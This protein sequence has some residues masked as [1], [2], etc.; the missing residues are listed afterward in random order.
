M[1]QCGKIW[2]WTGHR[3]QYDKCFACCMTVADK[4]IICNIYLRRSAELLVMPY[5]C[6]SCSMCL[7]YSDILRNSHIDMKGIL[8]SY[9][10]TSGEHSCLFRSVELCSNNGRLSCVEQWCTPDEKQLE[11]EMSCVLLMGVSHSCCNLSTRALSLVGPKLTW[12]MCSDYL[13]KYKPL[14]FQ[15]LTYDIFFLN[16]LI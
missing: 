14:H 9:S 5:L 16:T 1:R 15:L 13:C 2:S 4:L 10:R 7:V 8:H 11:D 3:W 12:L 6:L